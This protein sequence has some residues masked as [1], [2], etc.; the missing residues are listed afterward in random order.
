M[1]QQTINI[2]TVANDGTGD[3]IRD[4]FDKCNDNFTELYGMSGGGGTGGEFMIPIMAAAMTPRTTNGAAS[5]SIE[6]SS[7][8][9]ML[10]TL[11]FDQ[12]TDEFAQFMMPM[13]KS[14]N[15][16]TLSAI[17]VWTA[18][19][20]GDVIWGIQAVAISND[21]PVD[22]AFGSAVTVTDSVT[23]SGDLMESP[24]TAAMTVGGTPAEL[25]LVVFQV[26]RDADNGSDTL[27]AD[28]KL[29]GVRLT[30]TTNAADD[31]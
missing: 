11:D 3:P 30:I 18:S 19:A 5:G 2:G 1:S 15:E 6:T 7:N 26:Y 17:F 16:G 28:A 21:D 23:A 8:K 20:T 31:S 25:D 9:I 4:A 10:A 27:A 22:A 13:P 29:I 14:W 12:S 24:E